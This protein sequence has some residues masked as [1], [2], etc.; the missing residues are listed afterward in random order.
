MSKSIRKK[1]MEARLTVTRT[2]SR[3][4]G[5]MDRQAFEERSLPHLRALYGLALRLTGDASA[6]EDLVQE[7]YLKGLQSFVTVRDPDR[8]RP[9]LFQIL[10]RLVVD[11]HRAAGRE[12][13]LETPEDLDRFSLYDRIVDEDPLPYSDNLHEDFLAQ[14][15][16]EDVRR[17][18]VSI[19]EA[20]RVPLVLFYVEGLRYRELAEVLKCPVG[21]VMSRLH[22]G[23]KTLERL[24][25]DCALRRGLIKGDK[26]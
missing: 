6:A 17:A 9:W 23:R 25:W 14:F 1:V 24:L 12:V 13:P 2:P 15:R 4:E 22:R 18:L 7:T 3:P 20:Y 11:R 19:P 21:T 8:V 10:S 16:D 5:P 26:P